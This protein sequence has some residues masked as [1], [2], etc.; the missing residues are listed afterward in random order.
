M[1]ACCAAYVRTRLVMRLEV[2]K[3]A[4]QCSYFWRAE[5]IAAARAAA[6]VTKKSVDDKLGTTLQVGEANVVQHVLV[7]RLRHSRGNKHSIK[8]KAAEA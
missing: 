4:L 7:G 2:T 6:R 3:C 5:W 1:R 8:R